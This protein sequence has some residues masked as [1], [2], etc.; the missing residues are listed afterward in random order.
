MEAGSFA[1]ARKFDELPISSFTKEA[2]KEAKFKELTAVQRATL[3]HALCGRDVLGAAKTGS[4]K[5]LAFLIPVL[6]KLYRASWSKQDGLGA[7]II[8]PTRELALQIFDE[9]VK[10]GKRHSFSA[11]LLIGGKNVKDE[12]S[13]IYGMNILVCTPGRLL[14]HMDETPEFDC[15]QLQVLVLDEADRILDM[16]FA[17][18]LNAI[19]ENLPRDRQTMLFSATQTKSVKDLARLSL[20]DPEFLSVHAD[21]QTATPLKLQQVYSIVEVQEKMDVLWSFIK[22]HLKCKIIVFL[23]TCKQTRFVFEAFR[24]LRPGIPLRALHGKMKQMKRM[25]VYYEFNEAKSMVLF[26]TDIA[27][28]GLDFP[29]VDW[30]VQV[31]CPEDAAQY[32]HRVGRTAR[33]NQ[34]GKAMLLLM[35]SEKEGFLK[36]LETAKIPITHTKLNPAKRQPVTPSLQ[37]LLS[38]DVELKEMAQ[39]AV[40]SYVKSV[41]LMPAKDVFNLQGLSLPDFALSL[42]LASVPRLR[43]LKGTGANVGVGDR[44]DDKAADVESESDE[45]DSEDD[46]GAA[47]GDDD[48]EEEEEMDDAALIRL[49]EARR[50]SG[51]TAGASKEKANEKEN[52][53]GKEKEKS[54]AKTAVEEDEDDFMVVKRK[55]VFDTAA[56]EAEQAAAAAVTEKAGG[57]VTDAPTADDGKKKKKKKKLKIDPDKVTANKIVFDDEGEAQDRFALLVREKEF[58]GEGADGLDTGVHADP[59]ARFEAVRE[60]LKKRDR[61]DKE[62]QREKRREARL[63]QKAKERA[64]AE[65]AMGEGAVAVLG[66]ASEEEEGS[67]LGQDGSGSED[68]DEYM[69]GLSSDDEDGR[70]ARPEVAHLGMALKKRPRSESEE[71]EEERP[72]AVPVLKRQRKGAAAAATKGK[73]KV[74]IQGLDLQDAENIALQLLRRK[75]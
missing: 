34:G 52:K 60:A 40:A 31:D 73:S 11:G 64:Q 21:S 3:P 22:T 39:R 35:P 57:T 44:F 70:G 19:V 6:E 42:G 1:G 45:D 9:L 41:Y 29:S 38:K 36:R 69:G 16:G 2:L 15:T 23:N 24:K 4:G 7:L 26:A 56:E 63:A 47:A 33:F 49:M 55:D 72:A 50:G 14:Q 48:D 17:K 53:K 43:F 28:R 51:K 59:R 71:S 37:A 66:G 12:A 61:E 74:D 32:I 67:D 27:S 75:K 18:T 68:E 62:L 20:K 30:V 46:G 10:I 13:R 8:S 5:T 58:G 25:A 65:D 54:R